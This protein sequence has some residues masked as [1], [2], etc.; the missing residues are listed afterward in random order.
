MKFASWNHY[1][2][3]LK[4]RTWESITL[5]QFNCKRPEK[6]IF[7]HRCL[8]CYFI[9]CRIF[10]LEMVWKTEAEVKFK[11]APNL[12]PPTIGHLWFQLIFCCYLLALVSNP[13]KKQGVRWG[14]LP[15]MLVTQLFRDSLASNILMHSDNFT[16]ISGKKGFPFWLLYSLY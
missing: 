11:K 3:Q 2:I 12:K 10:F 16:L 8:C 1:Y 13:Y 6:D 9:F 14:L 7:L 5:V 15:R 4:E